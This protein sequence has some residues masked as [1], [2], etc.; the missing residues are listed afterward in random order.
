MTFGRSTTGIASGLDNPQLAAARRI[1]RLTTFVLVL[2]G[3]TSSGAV[4]ELLQRQRGSRSVFTPTGTGCGE[5]EHLSR[6]NVGL[7]TFTSTM[8]VTSFA[9]KKNS[10]TLCSSVTHRFAGMTITGVFMPTACARESHRRSLTQSFLAKVVWPPSRRF[11]LTG[12]SI[13]TAWLERRSDVDGYGAWCCGM[14]I[15]STCSCAK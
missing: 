10:T 1:S 5:R 15:R 7:D 8:S 6:P 14:N 2:A 11:V 12:E 9:S 13:G 3:H 4:R